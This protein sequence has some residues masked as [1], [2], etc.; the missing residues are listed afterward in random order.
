M[1]EKLGRPKEAAL[2]LER[3]LSQREVSSFLG[4]YERPRYLPAMLG[5]ARLYEEKLNDRKKAKETLHRLY[6][7][8]TT[9][10]MRD[11]ALWREAALWQK[12][13]DASTACARLKSLTSEFP[14]S[15]YVP[16][17]ALQC[18]AIERP[19]KSKAPTTCHD[20]LRR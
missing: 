9:S 6:T 15:R 17:A 2:L 13:G 1:E 20:Y 10:T 14:D 7:E 4:S 12:D 11:D 5:L 18:P 19:A 8:L 3:L 16:C